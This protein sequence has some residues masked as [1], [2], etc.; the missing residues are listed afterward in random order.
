MVGAS[1]CISA[2]LGAYLIMQ[3]RGKVKLMFFFFVRFWVPALLFLIFWAVQQFVASFASIAKTTESSGIA[4][5]AHVGGFVFGVLS[6]IYF[7][8]TRKYK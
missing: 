5:W 6:G 2:V 8:M 3:P 4:Y 1:G 7:R